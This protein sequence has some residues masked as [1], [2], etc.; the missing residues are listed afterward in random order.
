[1]Y[2]IGG[3]EPRVPP[4]NFKTLM[5]LI[6]EWKIKSLLSGPLTSFV[7]ALLTMVLI[8]KILIVLL[9]LVAYAHTMHGAHCMITVLVGNFSVCIYR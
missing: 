9:G 7:S 8:E 1:M 5:S 3:G 2:N 6:F 4:L